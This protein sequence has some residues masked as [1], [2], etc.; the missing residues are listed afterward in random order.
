MRK[1]V[2]SVVLL[3][4]FT[5]FSQ[6]TTQKAQQLVSPQEV[7]KCSQHHRMQEMQIK[8]PERFATVFRETINPKPK[9]TPNSTVKTTGLIYTIPVVF[10]IIHNNGTENISD[11][12]VADALAILNRDFRRLNAD[13]NTVQTPFQGMPTD[14]EIN[15]VFATVA[16]NGNCFSG[17]TRTQNAITSNGDD[18]QLQ[19]N[20]VI[21]GNNVYQ[22]VWAH[23]R[24]LNIYVCKDLGGAAGYTFLPNGGSAANATNMFYNGIF[25][26]DDYCGSIGTG[27]VQLSRALTHEV[28]HWMNLSHVWGDNNNPGNA[29][30]C[31][32]DDHVQDTPMC[33]GVT[34]CA[35]V[36]TIN[37]CNDLNDPNNYSSWTTNVIDNIENYMDY[38]YCSKMF[39]QGQVDRMRTALTSSV[40]GRSNIWS[41]PNL[42]MVGGPGTTSLCGIDFTANQTTMCAGTTVTYTT[43]TTSGISAY[44]WSFPGGTPATSNAVSPTVTYPTAGTY[45]ASLTVT[46]SSNGTTYPKS[47]TNYIQVNSNT[48]V[49]LPISQGFV[50]TTFPPTGWTL[51]NASGGTWSR[52]SSVGIT[53]T[54]G[55]SLL[56]DNYNITIANGANDELRLPKADITAYSSAQLTFDVAY[57]LDATNSGAADGLE[58]LVSTN[59]GATFTSVYSKSGATLATT[60]SVSGSF[61]PSGTQWRSETI[62]LTPFVGNSSVWIAFRN[63]AGYGNRL[64]VDNINVTGVSGA[65][66]APVASFSS[67]GTAICAGQSV[68]YT[69]TSTNNPTSY[70]WSFPGGT[71]STSTSASQVV[72]YPTAGT[73]NVSLTAT[74]LGGSN[75]SNQTGYITVNPVPSAPTIT[76]GGSTTFCQGNSVTLTSSA[77]SGNTWSNSA[78]GSSITVSSSG[79]YAV[80]TTVGSCVSPVSNSIFV[81]VNLNPTVTFSSVP[82]LC[83]TDG[84]FTLTQ[85]NPAGGNYSGTGV[86]GNQFNPATLG[87]GSTPVT[88]NF[89]NGNGCSGS[90]QTTVTVDACASIDENELDFI[91]VYPNPSVGSITINS[92]EVNLN[93][94]KVFNALGQVVY[95]I[96]N[97]ETSKLD[98]DLRNMA[99]G[100]YT[101]RVLT[102]VGTQHIPLVLEK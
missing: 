12:Q 38:S 56:F 76:A 66:T 16:P 91:S 50:S 24:Y 14:A 54:A 59:C 41:A 58:V 47:K 7:E 5:S 60:A 27:D 46:A 83:S 96:A 84:P 97:L 86:T 9:G 92:G 52:S 35:N 11:A 93:S 95:E 55:N 57:A 42:S 40:G 73:Y 49:S 80:T 43:S 70:S 22:G 51:V 34:S 4:G 6:V 44:S 2:F 45:N 100:V 31:A 48:T 77:P 75:A 87:I 88:Y 101:I 72:T 102:N 29:A 53:P 78:N 71:P 37:T 36:T 1:L 19:V 94:V 18:G 69:S 68:T 63:L 25:I 28:G 82:M 90:A 13:A 79:T 21:A 3:C 62:N 61:T 99:K 15:F 10:H 67:T 20:A 74:N 17:I 32:D 89:T 64:F 23:N 85:G 39:T 98:V 81:T 8:D 65:P 30:S 33:I 26:L